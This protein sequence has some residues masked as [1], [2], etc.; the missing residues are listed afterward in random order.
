[1]SLPL[2]TRFGADPTL[3]QELATKNYVDNGGQP[4]FRFLFQIPQAISPIASLRFYNVIATYASQEGDT[5]EAAMQTAAWQA[6]QLRRLYGHVEV[7]VRTE[8]SI[9]IFRINA[10]DGATLTVPAATNGDFDTGDINVTIAVGD[11]LNWSI[12]W[13]GGTLAIDNVNF[14]GFVDP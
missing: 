5:V 14:A 10:A 8:E 13:I 4:V 2:V 6:Y 1:M 12:S 7:N 11:L 3:P 9:Y